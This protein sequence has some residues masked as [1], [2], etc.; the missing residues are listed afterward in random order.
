MKAL[1]I[2]KGEA[3]VGILLMASTLLALF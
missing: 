3:G 1:N 2:L